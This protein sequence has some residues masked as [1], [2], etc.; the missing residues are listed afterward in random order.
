MAWSVTISIFL[1]ALCASAVAPSELRAQTVFRQPNVPSA[2]GSVQPGDIYLPASRVYVFVGKTGLGHEHGVVGQLRQGHLRLDA[3]ANAGELVFDMATFAADTEDARRN[4][5]LPPST[6]RSA[7]QQVN[8]NMLG[9]EVLDVARFGTANFVVKTV[10]QIPQPS[11][12]NLPQYE[13]AG[14][15]TL[16]GVTRPIQ[17]LADF[18]E[19][20][21][22]LHLRG[23]FTIMQSQFGITPFTKAFGTVGVSDEL[24]VWGDFWVAK[25]PQTSGQAAGP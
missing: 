15:F 21:G 11:S 12:R 10:R 6:D 18:E 24:K 8:A 23:G 17:V 22:W 4:V 19:Q 1:F 2:A 13:L 14:D 25:P 16:H 20:N 7:Q 5:G 3:S 9:P